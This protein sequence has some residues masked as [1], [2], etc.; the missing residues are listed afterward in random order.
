[1]EAKNFATPNRRLAPTPTED[2]LNWSVRRIAAIA[3][4]FPDMASYL[5]VGV[6][7]GLTFENIPLPLRVGVDPQP[8]FNLD[9]LPAHVALYKGPSDDYFTQLDSREQFDVIFLDGL[10]TYQQTYRDLMNAL[11]HCPRGVILIDDVVPSDDVSAIPDLEASFA[12]RQRRGLPGLPWHGDVFRV[13]LCVADH[14]LE[15]DY[16]TIADVD[17]PQALVWKRDMN[18]PSTAISDA[19]LQAYDAFQYNDVF[20]NGV[21][22]LF[23]PVTE[24]EGLRRA[25]AGVSALRQQKRPFFKR[26]GGR[27]PRRVLGNHR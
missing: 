24:T 23:H 15:L 1:V 10:H 18:T 8:R 17:N 11:R 5:E 6:E 21:P 12:E 26:L 13:M 9:E 4:A 14:H 22:E 25:I 2:R 20:Q 16:V 7:Y 3:R 19:L 27:L